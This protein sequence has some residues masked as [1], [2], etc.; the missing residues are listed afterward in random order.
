[1]KKINEWDAQPYLDAN[2]K[3]NY[4][5]YRISELKDFRGALEYIAMLLR[6]DEPVTWVGRQLIAELLSL[7]GITLI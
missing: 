4:V 3:W 7:K 1:M 5:W 6:E 2:G